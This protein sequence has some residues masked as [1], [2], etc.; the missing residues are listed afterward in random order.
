MGL[1]T[2]G[3][4]FERDR[5]NGEGFLNI[6]DAFCEWYLFDKYNSK[7]QLQH[8]IHCCMEFQTR[9]REQEVD[10]YKFMLKHYDPR[11]KGYERYLDGTEGS[12]TKPKKS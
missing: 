3:G 9:C 12:D 8:I 10:I 2:Q 11:F 1:H 4:E 5:G 7:T 6:T